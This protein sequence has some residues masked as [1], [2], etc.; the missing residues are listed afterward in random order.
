MKL[1]KPTIEQSKVLY[2]LVDGIRQK[3][4]LHQ[5]LRK[6]LSILALLMHS[7]TTNTAD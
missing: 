7:D 5:T 1:V 2:F 3:K 6:N 4:L